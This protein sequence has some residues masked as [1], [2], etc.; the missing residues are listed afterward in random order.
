MGKYIPVQTNHEI[1]GEVLVKRSDKTVTG[2]IL[3]EIVYNVNRKLCCICI[4]NHNSEP[5]DLQRGQTIGWVTSCI[6]TQKELGQRPEK[7]MENTQSIAGRIN[8]ADTGIG[9][10]SV[11][12]AEKAGW[13]ADSLQTVV[14]R[15]SYETKE[16]K[17]QFICESFQ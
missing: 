13:K 7:H 8:E 15:Q 14:N 17:C 12:N 2:L 9:G 11:E 1:Q 4:E 5:L 6:V 16:K 10:A 3:P